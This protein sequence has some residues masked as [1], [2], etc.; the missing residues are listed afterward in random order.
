MLEALF[1]LL[2]LALV[3]K[4]TPARTHKEIASVVEKITTTSTL[5]LRYKPFLL[6]GHPPAPATTEHQFIDTHSCKMASTSYKL[7]NTSKLIALFTA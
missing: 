6:C 4:A 7:S 5:P 1:A 3:M 2:P